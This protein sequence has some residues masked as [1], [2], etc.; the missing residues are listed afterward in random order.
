M[1]RSYLLPLLLPG[2]PIVS[3]FSK[4]RISVMKKE[5]T[6]WMVTQGDKGVGMDVE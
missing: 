5:L 2:I 4:D 3:L 1:K 6:K